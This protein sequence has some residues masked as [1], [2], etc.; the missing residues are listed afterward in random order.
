MKRLPKNTFRSIRRSISPIPYDPITRGLP[1]PCLSDLSLAHN[2]PV[3]RLDE[4]GPFRR[5]E[6]R[7][8]AA[9]PLVQIAQLSSD[10]ARVSRVP[11]SPRQLD[12][13]L[14][15]LYRIIAD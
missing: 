7:L 9:D 1:I 5:L 6:G 11:K 13:F 15:P 8:K 4:G 12:V 3:L 14:D 10:I 2:G